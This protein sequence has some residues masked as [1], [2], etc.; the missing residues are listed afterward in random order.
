M[1]STIQK[2]WKKRVL[3]AAGAALFVS[4]L[5]GVP[6][7]SRALASQMPGGPKNSGGKVTW[8]CVY[9]GRYPQS[10]AGGG[11][12]EAIKWRVLSVD[13][14]E[15]LLQADSNLDV[16]HYYDALKNITWEDSLIRCWLN[17]GW[18]SNSDRYEDFRKTGFAAVAFTEEE[19]NAIADTVVDN[20]NNPHQP[21]VNGGNATTDKIFLL[22]Y[23]E[24]TN[25]AY[26]FSSSAARIRK[27]TAYAAAGGQMGSSYMA[28]AGEPDN[29]WL[30]SPGVTASN[31]AIVLED[32]QI[33]ADGSLIYS[34]M[35]A[36]CPALR[37][38]LS[39]AGVW[40]YAGTV[41][42]DGSTT[43]GE[44]PPAEGGGQANTQQPTTEQPKTERPTTEQPKT[45]RPTTEQP[46]TERPTTEQPKTEQPK[47]EQPETE[48]PTTEQPKTESTEQETGY[49][50]QPETEQQP[51]GQD[52]PAGGTESG[53][54]DAASTEGW[55]DS[56][57]NG[58][59]EAFADPGS[60]MPAESQPGQDGNTEGGTEQPAGSSLPAV[61]S[62]KT[63][64][65]CVYKVTASSAAGKTVTLVK[66]QK[67]GR[68]KVKVPAA[69]RIAGQSYKVTKIGAKAF[70]KHK[71]LKSVTL[72]KNV[73]SVGKQAFS[74]CRKLKRITVKG[75]ALK[76]V[77]QGALKGIQKK[78]VIKVPRK[79][80]ARYK[81]LFGK[82]AGFK[83][84]MKV[85]A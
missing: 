19:R 80:L 36:V 79:K 9:F 66:S 51:G 77:G 13:N 37:L 78:A 45:E 18:I 22:S 41:G 61:G 82:K 28:S 72:G 73:T 15:A 26:G 4:M 2:R 48:R 60:G 59:T 3:Y 27:N 38:K 23:A 16:Y 46:K 31:A 67:T 70:G 58:S 62:S 33:N 34:D 53:T 64:S 11:S 40:S 76:S 12:K 1:F 68:K 50:G 71:N 69:V 55:P 24:A 63:I 25:S 84:G 56:G 14:G 5:C 52:T 42:S 8:D 10:D 85:K 32:G 83:K 21:Q 54:A 17:A 7:G 47:T 35:V 65:G 74:G 30:R 20:S 81:K 57:Q 43:S 39:S 29:W 75:T 44:N 6:A 49:S